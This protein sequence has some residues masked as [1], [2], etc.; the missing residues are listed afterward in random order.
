METFEDRYVFVEGES[1][2]GGLSVVRKAIDSREGTEVAIKFVG[3]S[4]DQVTRSIFDREVATLRMLSHP[5][6]IRLRQAGI[7][8]ESGTFYLVFDWIEDSFSNM[9]LRGV[10][11]EWEELF[12]T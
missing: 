9:L 4:N 1:R 2:S 3:G 12:S 7:E 10:S 6:I 8:K 5:H 11:Y